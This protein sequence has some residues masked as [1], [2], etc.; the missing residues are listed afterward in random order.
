MKTLKTN[1]ITLLENVETAE[2]EQIYKNKKLKYSLLFI[3]PFILFICFLACTI[4]E[5]QQTQLIETSPKYFVK[6]FQNTNALIAFCCLT[7]IS[8]WITI[9]NIIIYQKKLKPY[10]DLLEI[11]KTN[12]KIRHE[13]KIREKERQRIKNEKETNYTIKDIEN[14]KKQGE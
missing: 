6:T 10:K 3:I 8:F 12:D 9:I 4:Y 1:Q 7:G 2:A 13:E 11:A 5:I 14:T